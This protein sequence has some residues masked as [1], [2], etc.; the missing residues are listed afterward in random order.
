VV[1]ALLLLVSV[2]S[3]AAGERTTATCYPTV[4][5][6]VTV[7]QKPHGVA[8]NPAAKRLYVTNHDSDTLSVINSQTYTLVTTVSGG[9]GPNGVAYNPT[10]NLIYIAVRNTNRVRVLRASDYTLV[11]TIGVGSQPNGIAVN[12]TTNRIYVANYGSGTVSV[13][14]GATNTVLQT[15]NVG[16]EPAQIAINPATNKAYVSL[17][18]AGRIAV[19]SGSGA[20]TSV[21]IY[22]AGPYGIAVDTQRNLVYVATIDTFRIAAV[23]GATNQFLGWAEFRKMPGGEPVPL[24]ML[25][26]NPAIGSSGHLFATTAAVD[27]G[28]NKFL[29]IPKGWPEY[30][31]RP[32]ALNLNQPR[33][34][35]AFEASTCRVFAT[36]RSDNKVVAYLDG[37]PVC[38]TNLTAADYQVT[39]CVA[40]GEGGCKQILTR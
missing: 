22:S 17:H 16:S 33:E 26:V 34:G 23:D 7:Q 39:V 28:W 35:I 10:N 4:L 25:A 6:S 27:G 21:D 29:T 24:R 14:N 9:D 2:G 1:V 36:S 38:P 19:I 11:K 32:Y 40:D 15:L 12:A 18:G 20:V 37:D 30:F 13:I 5:A 8:V 31:A 3:G